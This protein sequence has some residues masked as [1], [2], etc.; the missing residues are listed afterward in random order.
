[1]PDYGRPIRYGYFLNPT[2]EGIEATIESAQVA[3]RLGLDLIGIQDHP[4]QPRFLDTWTLLTHLAART[5]RIRLFPDVA[6][7]AL[8]PPHTRRRS[9][10]GSVRYG[11]RVPR[12]T[13]ARLG[14]VRSPCR[15]RSRHR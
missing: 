5:E 8:R 14:H 7:L 1:M 9:L 2:A 10:V 12:S 13:R 3:D 15:C 6:T 4:Y 11:R